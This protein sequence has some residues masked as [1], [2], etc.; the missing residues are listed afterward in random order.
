[1]MGIINLKYTKAILG[2]VV[3]LFFLNYAVHSQKKI[4]SYPKEGDMIQDHE[5]TDI[6]N[7]SGKSFK[8]SDFRGKWLILDFWD[9]SCLSCVASFPKMDSISRMYNGRVEV[10]AVT[11]APAIWNGKPYRPIVKD[12]FNRRQKSYKLSFINAFDETV[13][14]KY[15]IF[16]LPSIFLIDPNGVIKAK[17]TS[18]NAAQ[19]DAFISGD[20]PKYTRFYTKTEV[21]ELN[22]IKRTITPKIDNLENLLNDSVLISISYLT[23]W[24]PGRQ[25]YFEG[26]LEQGSQPQILGRSAIS[27]SFE[28]TLSDLFRLAYTGLRGWG[29]QEDSLYQTIDVNL[30]LETKNKAIFNAKSDLDGTRHGVYNYTQ[31]LPVSSSSPEIR[32]T[33]LLQDLERTFNLSSKIERRELD[34]F[35]LI[36]VDQSKVDQLKTKG[37]QVLSHIDKN[38]IDRNYQNMSIHEIIR[39][40]PITHGLYDTYRFSRTG[41]EGLPVVVDKT[42]LKFNLDLDFKADISDWKATIKFLQSK[43]FDIV[44][45]KKMMECIVIYDK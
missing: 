18:I 23:K 8:I 14:D 44:K 3:C 24:Q 19:I 45:G 27:K 33:T 10:V 17:M 13:A 15:D 32:K 2:L 11:S 31:I 5:F 21:A 7:Y 35:Q 39:I 26:G 20:I 22:K 40:A 43:G 9:K 36:V 29:I 30:V 28:V 12:F 4:S 38:G 16:G 41:K 6:V 37:R 25:K 1:M 34:V 42:N